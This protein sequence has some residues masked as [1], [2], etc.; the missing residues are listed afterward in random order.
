MNTSF[1]SKFLL[2][3]V[4]INIVFFVFYVFD[5]WKSKTIF[6]TSFIYWLHGYLSIVFYVIIEPVI[7]TVNYWTIRQLY[8]ISAITN[9]KSRIICHY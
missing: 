3:I 2:Y 5:K 7:E 8:T 6:L 1:K 9:L 4:N